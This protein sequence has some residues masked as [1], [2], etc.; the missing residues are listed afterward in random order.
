MAAARG[1][2]KWF[3]GQ[4]TKARMGGGNYVD[5]A[6]DA[7]EETKVAQPPPPA[8]VVEGEG[9]GGEQQQQLKARRPRKVREV[10]EG[11]VEQSVCPALVAPITTGSH[12]GTRQYTKISPSLSAMIRKSSSRYLTYVLAVGSLPLFHGSSF[13][14]NFTG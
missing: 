13:H 3:A 14:T 10:R 6:Y 12:S 11:V 8:G 1:S 5:V 4:V 2:G 9:E 7:V